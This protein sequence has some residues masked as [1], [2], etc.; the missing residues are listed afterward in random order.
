VGFRVLWLYGSGFPF[1]PSFRNDRRPDPALDNSRR[2]PSTARLTID[3]DKYY[4][5]WGRT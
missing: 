4:K 1:T 5:V 3:G 2:L